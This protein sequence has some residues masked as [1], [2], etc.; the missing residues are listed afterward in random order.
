MPT[1]NPNTQSRIFESLPERVQSAI[2]AYANEA[3][4]SINVVITFAIAQFLEL[5]SVPVDNRQ[6]HPEDNS[7]L[8]DLPALLRSEIKNYGG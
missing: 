4:L 3:E 6:S 5:E 2:I 8:D 7:I 1:S